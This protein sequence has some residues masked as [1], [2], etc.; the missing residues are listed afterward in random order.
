MDDGTT[1]DYVYVVNEGGDT[2]SKREVKVGLKSADTYEIVSGVKE[3][4]EVIKIVF[5]IKD[6]SKIKIENK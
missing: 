6:G 2:V 5:G 1:A 3:G 4:E